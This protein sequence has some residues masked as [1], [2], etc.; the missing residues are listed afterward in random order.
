MHTLDD[1]DNGRL[2]GLHHVRLTHLGLTEFPRQLFDLADSLEIL[3]LS[4]NQ[5]TSLP[6]DLQRL[7]KL[8]IL[9]ASNNPFTELPRA[10]GSCQQLQM[11]GFKACR[12]RHV[13]ADS[14]PQQLRW[15]ILTDNQLTELPPSLGQRHQLQKLML[16]CN[17]LRSLPDLH[18]CHQ[19]ELLRL[20]SNQL[21]A[22]PPAVLQAPALAWTALGGNPMTQKS[23]HLTLAISAQTAISY[24][25]LDI[26]TLL[27]AGASGHIYQA[28]RTD[29]GEPIALKVFKA[30]YTS[31]GTP[32]SELAAGLAVGSHPHLLTPLAPVNGHPEGKLAM[33]L[34][35]LPAD[36]ISLA[37]PPSFDS[38]TRDV[39]AHNI[40]MT[41]ET[42]QRLLACI[43]SAIGH[44]HVHG[45]LHGDLY[46]HNILWDPHTGDA[47]LSDFG[48]AMLTHGLA[49]QHIAQLQAMEW[50]AFAHLQTEVLE[51]CAP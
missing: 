23:E 17:L 25:N 4:G 1:L 40:R 6:D 21:S 37:A 14:L 38:C 36:Y 42:A 46:A 34:P 35:L 15:L 19:L 7:T 43:R 16:S 11:V 44:L 26:G 39:Y 31:D 29:T 22:I 27:G 12:I 9:F 28:L 3:D 20:A 41:P 24:H 5:L 8:R 50:R 13:P 30:A 51:R 49:P 32:E 10:L 33:A 48:A 45:V 18:H 47:I 2:A